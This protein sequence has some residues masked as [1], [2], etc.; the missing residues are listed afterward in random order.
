[1]EKLNGFYSSFVNATGKTEK[2]T[3]IDI[4]C[5]AVMLSL[6]SVTDDLTDTPLPEYNAPT[7][8]APEAG[9]A[10]KPVLIFYG[11]GGQARTRTGGGTNDA[12]DSLFK[13]P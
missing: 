8:N 6:W 11:F 5:D 2:L 7:G 9:E 12:P 13:R 3:E 1:M 10:V 4:P